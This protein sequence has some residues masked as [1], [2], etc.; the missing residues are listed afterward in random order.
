MI[1]KTNLELMQYHLKIVTCSY[2]LSEIGAVFRERIV[3]CII[4]LIEG[5]HVSLLVIVLKPVKHFIY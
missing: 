4:N 2:L 3:S 1:V 5:H